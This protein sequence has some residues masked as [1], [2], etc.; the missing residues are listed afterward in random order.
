MGH[1]KTARQDSGER[2][3]LR[4]ITINR[5]QFLMKGGGYHCSLWKP[6][7]HD[8]SVNESWRGNTRSGAAVAPPAIADGATRL[9]GRVRRKMGGGLVMASMRAG[10]GSS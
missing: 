9:K 7:M 2:S 3:E 1:R 4:N 6:K 5:S 10:W 8:V